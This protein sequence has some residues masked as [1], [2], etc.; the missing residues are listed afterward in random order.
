MGK[1]IALLT[2]PC[3]PLSVCTVCSVGQGAFHDHSY[4]SGFWSLF[5]GRPWPVH[6]DPLDFLHIFG[7]YLNAA[8]ATC[9]HRQE[10]M[11]GNYTCFAERWTCN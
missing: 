4:D 10:H 6:G 11:K 3:E 8:S 2:L 7:K 5:S 9:Q 1:T